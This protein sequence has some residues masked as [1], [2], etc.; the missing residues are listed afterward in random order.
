MRVLKA[1]SSGVAGLRESITGMEGW[2][3]TQAGQE[4]HRSAQVPKAADEADYAK[5]TDEVNQLVS[6]IDAETK[7]QEPE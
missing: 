6:D 3:N 5:L 1:L 7:K 2:H 4:L